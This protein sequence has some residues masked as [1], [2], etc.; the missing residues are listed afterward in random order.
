MKKLFKAIILSF[1]TTTTF[2]LVL[3]LGILGIIFGFT[4]DFEYKI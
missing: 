3:I 1:I 2:F 4:K